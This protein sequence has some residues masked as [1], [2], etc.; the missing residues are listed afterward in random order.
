MTDRVQRREQLR[1]KLRLARE[2]YRRAATEFNLL[3]REVNSGSHGMQ[4]PDGAPAL[5]NQGEGQK[6]ALENYRRARNELM[7]F[8]RETR[9][10][11]QFD[12]LNRQ[13]AEQQEANL[14][15]RGQM[16]AD[17]TLQQLWDELTQAI[18]ALRVANEAICCADE[19]LRVLIQ[20]LDAF[21][22]LG[23]VRLSPEDGD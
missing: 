12:P 1:H 20:L 15:S 2:V 23:P 6:S 11:Q 16:E 21:R 7:E 3:A 4:P 17:R 10:E 18:E 22:E 13:T 8:L 14:S 9:V 19:A 5:A